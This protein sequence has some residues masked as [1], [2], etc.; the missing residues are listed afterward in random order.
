MGFPNIGRIMSEQSSSMSSPSS[1]PGAS[2]PLRLAQ[3]VSRFPMVTE[4]FVLYELEAMEKFGVKVELYSLLRER[5]KVVHPEAK[6]WV[7]RAHY[8]PFFSP[9]IFR[10]HWH[11]IRHDPGR[12]FRT[13]AEVLRGTVDAFAVLVRLLRS[14]RKRFDL[15][16]KW[17]N[18]RS[19][20]STRTLRTIRQ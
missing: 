19:N 4:T 14:S 8:L 20:T 17:R 9:K 1:F 18:K 16:T 2:R 6:K 3:L 10:A 5:P 13:I 15:F 11:F 7:R 12:Y